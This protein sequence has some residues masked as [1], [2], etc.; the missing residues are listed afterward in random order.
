[1]SE[2]RYVI[3]YTEARIDEPFDQSTT[4][5]MD[6]LREIARADVVIFSGAHGAA[7]LKAR[8]H[9]PKT[10]VVTEMATPTSL[11]RLT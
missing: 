4:L 2:T 7:V 3:V 10:G 11:N 8:D 6:Q 1:M 9:D 5:S